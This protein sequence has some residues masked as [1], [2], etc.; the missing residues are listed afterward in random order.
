[1]N[2]QALQSLAGLSVNEIK[3]LISSFTTQS[4]RAKQIYKWILR[5]ANDFSLMTDLPLTLQNELKENFNIYSSFVKACYEENESK[6]IVVSVK[7]SPLNIEAVLLSDEKKRLTACISTQAG[8]PA[9]CVF[10]KTGSLGFIR[11]LDHKEIIE[12]YLHLK[13]LCETSNNDEQ[14][15]KKEHAIDNI[16]IMGMGEPLL[17]LDN[18]KKALTFFNDK[19]GLNFSRRRITVSTCGIC[20]GLFEI[21]QTEF[22]CSRLALSLTTADEMLRQKLMPITA[23]NPLSKIHNALL[24][25]Q[26]NGGGRITLEI[27]L[28]AGIN[29]REKDAKSVFEFSK[30]L[31]TVINIIPWNPVEGLFF[32]GKPLKEPEKKETAEFIKMLENYNLKVT[33]RRRKGRS[34]MGAC[35]QLGLK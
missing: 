14:T 32:E 16:V 12:Q 5:G 33:M 21:A 22:F 9:G 20:E 17:N 29:T 15:I 2:T 1:M 27:P 30:G 11:N 25:F 8:C 13:T 26:K 24:L 35:G 31:E 4:F 3:E 10:C 23:S 18:L 34:I 19:E 6:K 7:D 28:L